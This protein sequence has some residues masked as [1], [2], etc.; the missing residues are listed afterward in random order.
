M[1]EKP[2]AM[3]RVW[4]L[5]AIPPVLF[6]VVIIAASIYFG[7]ITGG[8][9]QAITESVTRSTPSLLL[10]V[11]II[12][13]LIFG[14]ILW[15]EHLPI[16]LIG[17]QVVS[18]QKLWQEIIIGALPGVA[19]A[20]LYFSVLSPLM[21][22]AQKVLGDYVPPGELL[23]SLGKAALPFFLANVILA[24]FV[25]ENIYRGYG[26]TRLQQ[27]F[28]TPV[29][30]VISCFFFGLL[31]WAGGFWYIVLTSIVAG[32]LFA[33]LFVW[34]KNVVVAYAAQLALN[35]VEFLYVWLWVSR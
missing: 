3:W 5:F 2:K 14:A 22:T 6:L 15:A 18:G 19:L 4:A 25:E 10:I 13:L 16:R 32:G 8:D 9:A 35:L 1:E 24:P 27:R 23:P 20:F 34:R 33:G 28:S 26:I 7:M 29:A 11:Q 30:I 31:H 21:I 17:W 12:L